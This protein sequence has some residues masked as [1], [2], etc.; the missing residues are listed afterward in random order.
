MRNSF[1]TI[2]TPD[3]LPFARVLFQSIYKFDSNLDFYVLVVGDIKFQHESF[4]VLKLNELDDRDLVRQ[5]EI[6]YSN[7]LNSLRW[8]LKSLL[9][10]HLLKTGKYDQ[11]FFV[12]PDICFYSDFTFLYDFLGTSSILLS[13]HWGCMDPFV[14]ELYFNRLMT[15]GIYN[16]GFIGASKSGLNALY[17]WARMNIYACERDK[18]KG[19]FVDQA[20]LNVLPIINPDYK[21]ISHRGCNVAE[22]NRHENHRSLDENGNLLI[23]KE[24]PVVFIHFS[25][26]G[27]LV[28]HDPLLVPFLERYEKDLKRNGFEGSLLSPA[29]S[30]VNRKRLKSLSFFERLIRKTLGINR[31]AK[32]KGWE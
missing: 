27:Y 12:D 28:E 10:I 17:W 13:P 3:Y 31:F 7:E 32:F 5:I 14:S 8:S 30:F 26:L 22:W 18:N 6:K 15:D 24:F 4:F 19:L 16:G 29:K 11:V 20:Y 2:I 23:N 1:C 21:A 9:M 25:N